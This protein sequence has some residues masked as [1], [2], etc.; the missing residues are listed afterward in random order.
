M[1]TK[2]NLFKNLLSIIITISP[3]LTVAQTL[4][5]VIP[6]SDCAAIIMASKDQKVVLETLKKYA[7]LAPSPVLIRSNNGYY[8]AALGIFNKKEGVAF[9][10]ENVGAN[11]IPKDSICTNASRFIEILHPNESFTA[12]GSEVTAGLVDNKQ[13]SKTIIEPSLK[14]QLQL[15]N[16]VQL[17]EK[18]QIEKQNEPALSRIEI[19]LKEEALIQAAATKELEKLKAANISSLNEA[20]KEEALIQAAATKELEK[21]KAANIN[22]LNEA[23]KAENL[24]LEF[25]SVNQIS[26]GQLKPQ[27]NGQECIF[28]IGPYNVAQGYI[29]RSLQ[30]DINTLSNES[31]FE[32]R[33]AIIE[34]KD[35][36]LG[37]EVFGSNADVLIYASTKIED[38]TDYMIV[39]KVVTK[40]RS[41][42]ISSPSSNCVN[43]KRG[44]FE[45]LDQTSFTEKL[46]EIVNKPE[47]CYIRLRPEN[48]SNEL[49]IRDFEYRNLKDEKKAL[50]EFDKNLNIEYKEIKSKLSQVTGFNQLLYRFND[51][52]DFSISSDNI[53]YISR[54]VSFEGSKSDVDKGLN[55][56]AQVLKNIKYIISGE[57]NTDKK[58]NKILGGIESRTGV[59]LTSADE[60]TS[61]NTIILAKI[62]NLI[63][64]K[65][66][67]TA[68][69]EADLKELQATIPPIFANTSNNRAVKESYGFMLGADNGWDVTI[70]YSI[71]N[72]KIQYSVNT[73]LFR[74]DITHDLNLIKWKSASYKLVDLKPTFLV[75]CDGNCLTQ[76]AYADNP[77]FVGLAKL[78]D[79][80]QQNFIQL[81]VTVTRDRFEKALKDVVKACPGSAS[82]Y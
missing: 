10:K 20:K 58:T 80:R 6:S 79:G 33:Y 29:D 63:L 65:E 77:E 30:K 61:H 60:I 64:Q 19:A 73:G 7:D 38:N 47:I 23:K 81:P 27:V 46:N 18:K 59:W 82:K 75:A 17:S 41:V 69:K 48:L 22:S 70:G 67:I 74:L 50:E 9:I 31:G 26:S 24:I 62:D 55:Q 51:I 35:S 56:A 12:L 71:D 5:S 72:C 45:T 14:G 2:I 68:K 34:K 42:G 78:A 8:A 15:D 13:I 54:F 32:L 44:Y 11:R 3:I 49:K 4:E 16:S 36:S 43:V 53:K 37:Y 52:Q 1:F 57:C 39:G 76:R 66:D 25:P 21:L 28:E 40:L